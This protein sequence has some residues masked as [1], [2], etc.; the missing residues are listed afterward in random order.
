MGYI[1]NP[2]YFERDKTLSRAIYS[3]ICDA[4][5]NYRHGKAENTE[6]LVDNYSDV[7]RIKRIK[8]ELEEIYAF[9]GT[10]AGFYEVPLLGDALS[11][12]INKLSVKAAN[13][14]S[15]QKDIEKGF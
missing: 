4:F 12:S 15:L 13:A 9:R 3:V 10:D 7:E 11:F 5:S 6:I 14:G 8:K 1:I 2:K